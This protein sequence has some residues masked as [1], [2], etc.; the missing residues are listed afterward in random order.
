MQQFQISRVNPR[1]RDGLSVPNRQRRILVGAMAKS[2]RHESVARRHLERP[3]HREIANTL[4]SQRFDETLSRSAKLGLY[5][6]RHHVSA[7]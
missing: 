3:Q 1:L 5:R 2:G 7:P 4:V 6:S